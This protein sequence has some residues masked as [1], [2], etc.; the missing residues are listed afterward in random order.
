MQI[1]L[2]YLERAPDHGAPELAVIL[3]EG[4]RRR[5]VPVAVGT[6]AVQLWQERPD[7]AILLELALKELSLHAEDLEPGS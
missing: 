1:E 3:K 4:K 7:E 2:S 6:K 5:V